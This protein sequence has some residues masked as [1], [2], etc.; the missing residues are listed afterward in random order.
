MTWYTDIEHFF[1][2]T[3]E[4]VL[5]LIA[6][7]KTEAAVI[8]TDIHAALRWVSNQAPAIAADVQMVA[9]LIKTVGVINP[10]VEA[11]IQAAN[12]A[13]IG[14]NAFANA[15]KA[16]KNDT[17]A[18]VQGYVAVK[19]AQAAVATA[20]TAAAQSPSPAPAAVAAA[21]VNTTAA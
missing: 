17:A 15:T 13:V 18:V 8:E 5:A 3:E 10:T 12:I 9:N 21:T 4:D 11:A 2:T 19:Q 14:I 20:A 1:K 7:I 6:K 16:G